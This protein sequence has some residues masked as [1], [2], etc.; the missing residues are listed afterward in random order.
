MSAIVLVRHGQASWGTSDYDA[1]SERG[2]QQGRHLGWS[3][4]A[5]GWL[6]T[7]AYAGSMR[8]HAQT[9]VAALAAAGQSDGYEV[10]RGW[11]EFAHEAV[12]EAHRPGFATQD[13]EEFQTVFVEALGR[14]ASGDHDADYAETYTE[15]VRRVLAA[16]DRA[17][18][19]VGKGEAVA[20]FTSGGPIAVIAAHLLSGDP[21]TWTPEGAALWPRLNTVIVNG[22][23]TT[24][25]VGSSGR[26]LLSFNEHTHLPRRDVT[27]R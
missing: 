7:R 17:V 4:E 22:S 20:V 5:A 9:A 11:D 6:P 23:T 21:S 14:W 18:E 27:Y 25:V 3:W 15:F 19:A 8:R 1:L 16:F 24:A 2:E 26:T 10:D 13:P 12:V